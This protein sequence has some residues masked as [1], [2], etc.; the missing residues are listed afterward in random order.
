[1]FDKKRF[2]SVIFTLL[3]TLPLCADINDARLTEVWVGLGGGRPD[4]THDWIEVTNMGNTPIDTGGLAY[5]DQNPDF[6]DANV[7]D[8]IILQP[9]ESAVFLLDE[10]GDNPMF[11][12]SISEFLSVW[13]PFEDDLV[14][15]AGI[16]SKLS[17]SGDEANIFNVANGSIIDTLAYPGSLADTFST[18]ERTGDGP[19]DVRISL[20]GENGAFESQAYFDE[21]TG[22]LAVDSVGELIMLIGSPGMYQQ[23]LLGDMNC[24]GVV[25]LL[26]VEPFVTIGLG[27][28]FFPKADINQD[29]VVN[30]L[31][32]APFVALLS[33]E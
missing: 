17:T 32:I 23:D 4:G 18:I 9:G 11:S 5:D 14:G 1:M 19:F 21:D 8:S 3:F 24:D 29:G 27:G 12:S 20:L 22:Q 25:D 33:G 10:A 26:D 16:A 2:L 6:D 13:V 28:D 30:L 7:L 31:D 15:D